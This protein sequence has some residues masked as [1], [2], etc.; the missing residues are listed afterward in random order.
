MVGGEDD[1]AV[2]VVEAVEA[3]HR[4]RGQQVHGR[5]HDALDEQHPG[6]RGPGS[7]RAQSVS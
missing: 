4:R 7:E 5:P 2:E 1:R 3:L 6:Q